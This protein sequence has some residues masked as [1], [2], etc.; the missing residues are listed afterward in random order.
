MM[1][2]ITDKFSTLRT[3]L[4]R[5]TLEA[6]AQ[7]IQAIHS[8]KVPKGDPIPVARVAAIQ[9]AKN[10][11][12]IIPY[13]H[14]VPLE[15]VSVEFKIN[16]S[17]IEVEASVKAV[18]KTGVEMEA[19]TAA[20]VALLTLYDM[21]KPLDDQLRIARIDLIQKSGGKT[22]FVNAFD[23]PPRAS[24][25]VMSD[26]VAA[27]RKEDTSGPL[28]VERLQREGF[29]VDD[30]RVIADDRETIEQWLT[31]YADRLQ[32]DL[33]LTCGGTGFSPRDNT[34]EAMAKLIQREVPG[35]PEAARAFGQARMPYSMLARGQAGIRGNTLM[36]NLPGSRKGTHDYLSV[37]FPAITHAIHMIRGEGH[38]D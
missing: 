31:N 26:S 12:Q 30:Y 4:A 16:D 1:R 8:Q 7:T 22:D 28:I 33:V 6:S 36:V 14:P 18:H 17:S 35:I 13:C 9:A 32:V 24:V 23:S 38:V 29:T 2:D 3:A 37:I 19:L 11:S 10:T 25:L 34:P 15:G 5:G 27:G 20:S 21:L